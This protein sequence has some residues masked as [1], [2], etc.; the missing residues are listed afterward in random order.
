MSDA[1]IARLE[2]LI[3]YLEGLGYEVHNAHR[4]EA[5]G[6]SFLAPEEC[7]RQDF[8]EI[9]ACELFVAFPGAPPSPGTHVEIGWASALGKRMV[10]LL[11][12]GA[13]YAFLVEGLPSVANVT[14]LRIPPGSDGV[15][16]LAAALESDRPRATS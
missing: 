5:W 10:L 7:T 15:E 3:A 6:R 1:E 12:E 11:E 13:T 14:L 9:A 2:R 16:Q 4:R 8:D